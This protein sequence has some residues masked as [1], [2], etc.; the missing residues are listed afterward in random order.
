MASKTKA[1][2]TE[3]NMGSLVDI[4]NLA[5]HESTLKFF[6]AQTVSPDVA[7]SAMT[8]TKLGL[9]RIARLSEVNEM[10]TVINCASRAVKSRYPVSQYFEFGD[11]QTQVSVLTIYP[12]QAEYDADKRAEKRVPTLEIQHASDIVERVY[13]STIETHTGE[14]RDLEFHIGEKQ[15]CQNILVTGI[16]SVSESKGNFASSPEDYKTVFKD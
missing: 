5:M 13:R 12:D 16:Y 6:L 2:I 14:R 3:Q 10:V 4:G 15:G 7:R 1:K 9:E 11:G 8:N